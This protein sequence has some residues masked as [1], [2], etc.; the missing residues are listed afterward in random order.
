MLTASGWLLRQV[1]YGALCDIHNNTFR[2]LR[3][4]D[5]S[6]AAGQRNLKLSEFTGWGNWDFLNSS[7]VMNEFEMFDLDADPCLPAPSNRH[8]LC[9]A[10][11]L[12]V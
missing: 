7:Y 4:V 2:T 11:E 9:Y 3:V 5:P 8:H 10:V 1:R 12:T 6:A